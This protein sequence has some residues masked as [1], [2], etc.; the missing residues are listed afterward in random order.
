MEGGEGVGCG[1]R[2][3]EKGRGIYFPL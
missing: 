1:R 2:V 3:R